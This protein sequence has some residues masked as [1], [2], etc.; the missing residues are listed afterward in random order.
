MRTPALILL[1][2]AA[3]AHGASAFVLHHPHRRLPRAPASALRAEQGGGGG[4]AVEEH[5]VVV[6]GSGIG[7]LTAAATAA[8]YGLDVAVVES[9]VHA[10]GAAHAF[11]RDGFHF[12]SGPSLFSG[13]S[14]ETSP[15]PLKHVFDFIG[16]QV[17]WITYDTWGVILPDG[18]FD[19]TI[20]PEPFND[21]LGTCGGGWGFDHL[22]CNWFW[23]QHRSIPSHTP[24]QNSQP[25]TAAPRPSRSGTGS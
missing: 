6:I 7:G 18:S 22:Q 13:L 5:D 9:H 8:T 12:D 20:G 21:I 16:E 25:S 4:G 3:A 10:G 23:T 11:E 15:N 1:L 14:Q 17:D 2:A 19:A 24:S